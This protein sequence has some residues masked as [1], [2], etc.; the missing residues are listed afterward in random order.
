MA[1][2][3]PNPSSTPSEAPRAHEGAHYPNPSSKP[4]LGPLRQVDQDS[5]QR[6]IWPLFFVLIL[7]VVAI[8]I[9]LGLISGQP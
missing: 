7:C 9:V 3:T 4:L 2:S 1:A 8:G 6:L 5:T